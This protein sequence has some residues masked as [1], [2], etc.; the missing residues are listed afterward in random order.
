MIRDNDEIIKDA[1]ADGL[2]ELRLYLGGLDDLQKH[3]LTEII[4]RAERENNYYTVLFTLMGI[5]DNLREVRERLERC[6]Y[7]KNQRKKENLDV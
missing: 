1:M 4:D 3:K 5:E 6:V 2:R 7:Y